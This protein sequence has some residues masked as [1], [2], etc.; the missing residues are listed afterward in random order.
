MDYYIYSTGYTVKRMR[1]WPPGRLHVPGI[2]QKMLRFLRLRIE[3][4]IK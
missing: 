1:R 3:E 2:P 4:V